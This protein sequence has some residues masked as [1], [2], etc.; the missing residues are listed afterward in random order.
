M[1]FVEVRRFFEMV[2]RSTR[3]SCP[4]TFDIRLYLTRFLVYTFARSLTGGYYVT[5]LGFYLF[6]RYVVIVRT[7]GATSGPSTKIDR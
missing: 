7:K 4:F 3:V 6:I 2:V 1:L 5:N